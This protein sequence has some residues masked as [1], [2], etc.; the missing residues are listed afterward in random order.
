MAKR[1]IVM[2]LGEGEGATEE[3]SVRN[4]RV[5]VNPELLD[6][7]EEQSVYNEG[8][9]SVPEQFAEV[10]RPSVVHARWLDVDGVKHEESWGCSPPVSSTRWI[11]WRA[12]SS[13]ITW[14]A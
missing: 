9:L 2:D 8:C 1:L 13:S 14:R 3:Q 6:P 10:E 7:S 12:S 11:I 4:P 5:F